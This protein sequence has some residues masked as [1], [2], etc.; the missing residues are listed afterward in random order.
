[1]IQIETKVD[2]NK[3][4]KPHKGQSHLTQKFKHISSRSVKNLYGYLTG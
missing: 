4:V 2:K 1:M 3:V